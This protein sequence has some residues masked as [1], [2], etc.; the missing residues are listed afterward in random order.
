M[1]EEY[2]ININEVN[3]NNYCIL[4]ISLMILFFKYNIS[5]NIY[6]YIN[7]IYDDYN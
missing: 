6:I 1:F 3:K 4:N 7:Y 2:K 5:I